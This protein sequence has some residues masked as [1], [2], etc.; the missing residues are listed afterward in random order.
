MT[1]RA[2]TPKP[3]RR[4]ESLN[5]FIAAGLLLNAAAKQLIEDRTA[6]SFAELVKAQQEFDVAEAAFMRR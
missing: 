1:K 4:M 5:R 6:E 3:S 2:K